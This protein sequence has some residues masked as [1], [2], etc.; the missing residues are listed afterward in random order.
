MSV[1]RLVAVGSVVL[2]SLVV[3]SS[4][5]AQEVTPRAG[6]VGMTSPSWSAFPTTAALVT[7][8]SGAPPQ[9]SGPRRARGAL[10]GG[11][12]GLV[13]GG[14]LGGLTVEG[15]GD[16]GFGGGLAESAATAEAVVL[17][18]VF[19]AA[20]GAVLGA[21]VFAPDRPDRRETESALSL[22]AWSA[23]G[24]LSVAGSLAR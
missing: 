23:A 15:D 16:D 2:G 6:F 1:L 9:A 17:G 24:R 21:T 3:G 20:I 7:D 12:I 18:A 5:V 13:A 10:I 22:R 8:E 4:L 19:G 14:L 11:G